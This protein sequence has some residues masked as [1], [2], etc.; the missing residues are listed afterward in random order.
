MEETGVD[1]FN[2]EYI[3]NPGDFAAVVDLVMP[4][5]QQRGGYKTHC[6][7]GTLRAKLYGPG[8]RAISLERLP[9]KRG[10]TQLTLSA[11]R[12][13]STWRFQASGRITIPK[14]KAERIPD[15]AGEPLCLVEAYLHCS[16]F[17]A[18]STRLHPQGG[19]RA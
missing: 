3:V 17:P 10:V 18:C 11:S 12:S 4:E 5:L 16:E 19:R 15:P 9:Q 7:D 6:E 1:G 13:Q 8:G 2:L 14:R